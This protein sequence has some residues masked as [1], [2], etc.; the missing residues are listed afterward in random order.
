V[1]VGCSCGLDSA[2]EQLL[3]QNLAVSLLVK[4]SVQLLFHVQLSLLFQGLFLMGCFLLLLLLLFILLLQLP[5]LFNID[6]LYFACSFLHFP[7]LL[8]RKGSLD[9]RPFSLN[10]RDSLPGPVSLDVFLPEFNLVLLVL[11]L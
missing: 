5:P 10:Q 3:V 2:L 6:G 7:E 8:L 4:I 11:L 9:D 1:L